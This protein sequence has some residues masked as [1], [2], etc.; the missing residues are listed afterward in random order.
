MWQTRVSEDIC[1]NWTG[2]FLN[3]AMKQ[4][5]F[6]STI[7][8][9][10][11]IITGHYEQ[12]T[13]LLPVSGTDNVDGVVKFEVGA[14]VCVCVCV[15]VR[16]FLCVC[17]YVYACHVCVCACVRACVRACVQAYVRVWA[18]VRARLCVCVCVRAL[19]RNL[20]GTDVYFLTGL[21]V[22]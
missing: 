11:S 4:N 20:T 16:V 22:L 21:L 14:R 9:N 7:K 18:R 3:K 10:H 17:F 1:V 12:T 19:A 6:L 15:Y 5:N 13:G 8:P 2:R